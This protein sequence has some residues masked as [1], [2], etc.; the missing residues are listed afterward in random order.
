VEEDT[1]STSEDTL[2]VCADSVTESSVP[3]SSV[4][5]DSERNCMDVVEESSG[6]EVSKFICK[7]SVD[8]VFEIEPETITLRHIPTADSPDTLE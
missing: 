8:L 4:K 3:R 6:I 5:V 7:I 2:T 1:A